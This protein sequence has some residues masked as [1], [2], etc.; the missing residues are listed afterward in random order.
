MHYPFSLTIA[1]PAYNEAR[2]LHKVVKESLAFANANFKKY[3]ILLIDDGSTDTTGTIMDELARENPH[4]AVVHHRQ[5]LGFSGAITSC[6]RRAWA[7]WVFLLPADGQVDVADCRHFLARTKNHDVIVGYRLN[8]PEGLVRYVNSWLYH[9]LWRL[10]FGLPLKEIT[11]AILWRKAILDRL[12]ITSSPRS[13]TVQAELLYRAWKLNY[14]FTEVGIPYYPRRA[15]QAKGTSLPMIVTTLSE[16]I[17]LWW[18]LRVF[19]TQNSLQN[20][21]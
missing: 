2:S 5:N 20:P 1:I 19:P 9:R 21:I 14:R 6:Y 15:G 18:Q 8:R 10:L 7:D 16:L 4:L 13:A 17:R 11:T 3:E 12:P